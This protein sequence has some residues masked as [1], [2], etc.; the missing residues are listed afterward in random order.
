[1]NRA[2]AALALALAVGIMLHMAAFVYDAVVAIEDAKAEI[3]ACNEAAQDA[4]SAVMW[5][6]HE[7]EAMKGIKPGRPRHTQRQYEGHEL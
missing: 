2:I 4:Y 3:R 1:V 6:K 7:I 5:A